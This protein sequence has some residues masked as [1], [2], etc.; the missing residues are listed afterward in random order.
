MV[1]LLLWTGALSISEYL[2]LFI[3]CTG[4]ILLDSL[5]VWQK[6]QFHQAIGA[7]EGFY[8]FDADVKSL[9]NT[10]CV[11][12]PIG[13]NVSVGCLIG[14]AIGAFRCKI[15]SITCVASVVI[16]STSITLTA[17]GCIYVVPV[18][19]TLLSLHSFA[20]DGCVPSP[21]VA[22]LATGFR[23]VAKVRFAAT[24][25]GRITGAT[26]LLPA[27]T[28]TRYLRTAYLYHAIEVWTLALLLGLSAATAERQLTFAEAML[29]YGAGIG[30]I[31]LIGMLLYRRGTAATLR[32]LATFN[33]SMKDRSHQFHPNEIDGLALTLLAAKEIVRRYFPAVVLTLIVLAAVALALP[34]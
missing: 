33:E 18:A 14:V 23:R 26:E 5:F 29:A 21:R 11:S 4:F 22:F 28:V 24:W 34:K 17:V 30:A 9:I 6:R 13:Y 15:A 10:P 19:L 2:W 7:I 1:V 20:P 8:S 12:I 32:H 3:L 16:W 27:L 25:L 31:F